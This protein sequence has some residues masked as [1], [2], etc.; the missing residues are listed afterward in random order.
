MEFPIFCVPALP[1]VLS[2]L[3][4][5]RRIQPVRLTWEGVTHGLYPT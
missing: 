4:Y 1:P 5:I 2:P 3:P